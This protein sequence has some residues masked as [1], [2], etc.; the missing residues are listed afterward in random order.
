MKNIGVSILGGCLVA[1][2]LVVGPAVAAG[3]PKNTRVG[4]SNNPELQKAID[5]RKAAPI[6]KEDM[7]KDKRAGATWQEFKDFPR[8]QIPQQEI[9]AIQKSAATDSHGGRGTTL[10]DVFGGTSG[11]NNFDY[12][13]A[14]WGDVL[15]VNE[16]WVPWGYYRHAGMYDS[17]FV[18][19][20]SPIYEANTGPLGVRLSP[21]SAFRG[22]DEQ[23]GLWASNSWP[24]GYWATW[25]AY[26]QLG[27][28][29]SFDYLNKYRT[30]QFYCS[31]LVWRSYADQGVDIDY[32]G[33]GF[34]APDDI[35]EDADMSAWQVAY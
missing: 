26:D 18:T 31:S 8:R 9:D 2:T 19:Y 3:E 10:G 30:D 14:Y 6:R 1:A 16:G 4:I 29:Y 33:G 13:G 32:D 5:A 17:D 12:S 7:F 27:K 15:L 22:Y 21:E 25:T 23:V 34:V 24:A 28:P 35:F 20:G 11:T